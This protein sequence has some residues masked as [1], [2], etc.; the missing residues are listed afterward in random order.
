[1]LEMSLN[2]HIF[3]AYRQLVVFNIFVW[4]LK[5]NATDF[6]SFLQ[7]SASK[8]PYEEDPY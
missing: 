5:A 8:T 3:G 2:C 4:R 6:V 1:M 7:K